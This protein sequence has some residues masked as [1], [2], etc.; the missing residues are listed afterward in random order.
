MVEAGGHHHERGS[1]PSS[2]PNEGDHPGE[3]ERDDA[4]VR[5]QQVDEAS[6]MP[7]DQELHNKTAKTARW[8]SSSAAI[9][10]D[11]DLL[12]GQHHHDGPGADIAEHQIHTDQTEDEIE[13]VRAE[14]R[15]DAARDAL[16][17]LVRSKGS[18][19]QRRGN[20]TGTKRKRKLWGFHGH[21]RRARPLGGLHHR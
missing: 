15:D 16:R 8:T 2:L 21:D 6:T 3:G 9:D 14:R 5:E 10:L 1:S 13:N 20:V 12:E 18:A 17:K 19:N 7:A 11:M 4:G